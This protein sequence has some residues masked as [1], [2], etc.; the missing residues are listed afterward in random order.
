M[1]IENFV[2]LKWIHKGFQKKGCSRPGNDRA[3]WN[4]TAQFSPSC[5]F[6]EG[7]LLVFFLDHSFRAVAGFGI[8]DLQ[9]AQA[10]KW[11]WM[12]RIERLHFYRS[13][14]T[15]FFRTYRLYDIALT[16]MASSFSWP[17]PLGSLKTPE[18]GPFTFTQESWVRTVH[19][20]IDRIKI[21]DLNNLHF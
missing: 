16:F 4:W 12:V 18:S 11:K 15:G 9:F 21:S 6:L 5:L 2:M 7:S 20:Q 14:T 13:S 3:L 1:C 8:F 10:Q 17:N 19:F